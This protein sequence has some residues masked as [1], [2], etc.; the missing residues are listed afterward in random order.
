V[1]RPEFKIRKSLPW[2]RSPMGVDSLV[3]CVMLRRVG[4]GDD[5]DAVDD[6]ADEGRD[7]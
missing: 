1:I 3:D 5:E 2:F 4:M 7:N 6:I